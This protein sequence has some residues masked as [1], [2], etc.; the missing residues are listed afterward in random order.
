MIPAGK[1]TFYRLSAEELQRSKTR[2]SIG[3]L[4]EKRLHATLKRWVADDFSLH[5]VRVR[6]ET[7]SKRYA[8]ADVCLENGEIAEIQTGALYPLCRKMDFYMRETT[9]RVTLIHPV[10]AEKYI[11]RI[12][13]GG[14]VGARRK[15]PKKE[16]VL[17]A[18]GQLKPFVHYFETGRFEVWFVLLTAEEF[19]L[20]APLKKGKGRGVR[21]YELI[22][23][24]LHGVTVL[25]GVQDLLPLLPPDLPESFTAKEF[26]AKARP[27]GG[28]ALYDLLAVLEAGGILQKCGKKGR[29]FVYRLRRG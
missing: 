14:E 4:A 24:E 12:G 1:T 18:A 26:A 28:F 6:S 2:D 13:G 22:P 27:I 10:L 23:T 21:R 11:S 19:R 5:E 7:G 20:A 29:S 3:L 9:R 25:R 17:A 8:V 16:T 15:S